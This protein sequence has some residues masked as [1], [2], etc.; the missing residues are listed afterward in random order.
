ML[1]E[2][3]PKPPA[4][5]P[6]LPDTES[7]TEELTVRQLVE[8]HAS[9]AECAVCHRRIDP[10]GFALERYDPIGRFRDK[11]LAGRPI[12]SRARLKDGT[13][14]EGLDGLRHYVLAQRGEE[15]QR[16]FCK[17]LL[18]Y[19]LGRS[20]SLPDQPLLDDMLTALKKNDQRLS[21]AVQTI[22]Q[23]KQFRWHR[24]LEATRDE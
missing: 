11:D 6:V 21:V 9:V 10:F 20:I 22:V 3:L 13:E 7:A 2:K 18:G 1:G 23:S 12:D 15:F 19:A 14:F 24:G 4:N 16:H 5:V 8:K 17:K